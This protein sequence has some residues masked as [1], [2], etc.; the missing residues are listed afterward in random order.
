MDSMGRSVC[1]HI[2]HHCHRMDSIRQVRMYSYTLDTTVCYHG[3]H[4]QVRMLDTPL[5]TTVCNMDQHEP[6]QNVFYTL[7]T[8]LSVTMDGIGRSEC[9]L[10]HWIS[11]HPV[12]MDGIGRSSIS[13]A[14]HHCLLTW[15]AWAG[16]KC[17]LHIGHHCLLLFNMD[18]HRHRQVRNV[19]SHIGHHCSVN[20]DGI[21]RSEC[22]LHIG[23]H[24]LLPWTA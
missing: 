6:G 3:R 21:G 20:M 19:F 11:F 2:G 4:G 18:L 16:G 5:D 24:C 9:I 7:W 17:I 1:L 15:T 8:P 23:H 13:V 14:G 10:L 12:T 22:I